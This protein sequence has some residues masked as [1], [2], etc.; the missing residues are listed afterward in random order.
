MKLYIK[1]KDGQPDGYPMLEENLL[2]AWPEFDPNNL[3]PDL[4]PFLRVDQEPLPRFHVEEGSS[5]QFVDGLWQDVWHVRPMTSEEKNVLIQEVRDAGAPPYWTFDEVNVIWLPPSQ[6]TLN[7][8]PG[9]A[10]NVI[11]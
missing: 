8:I 10:P 4:V 7:T 6:E 2:S 11:D 5:I 9:S 3:T 1:I